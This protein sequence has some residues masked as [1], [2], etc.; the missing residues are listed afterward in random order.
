MARGRHGLAVPA[1]GGRAGAWLVG[2]AVQLLRRAAAGLTDS[3]L[4]PMRLFHYSNS[5]LALV[6]IAAAIDPLL[7]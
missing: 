5:Y 6:F 4:N 3:A 7:F 1:R 2:E